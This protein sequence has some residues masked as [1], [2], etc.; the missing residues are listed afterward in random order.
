MWFETHSVHANAGAPAPV[1]RNGDVYQSLT[2]WV[3]QE[4][5]ELR[6]A[7]VADHS[8]LPAG[9]GSGHLKRPRWGRTMTHQV[10]AAVKHVESA[11]PDAEVDRI[12]AEPERSKLRAGDDAVLPRR[13]G[14]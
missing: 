7:S 11:D 10:D 4:L 1:A 2:G 9:E 12:A 6:G 5:P 8:A 14:G 3:G 13:Q